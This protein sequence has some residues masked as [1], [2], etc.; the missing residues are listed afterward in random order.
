V[1]VL[2]VDK[3][4]ERAWSSSIRITIVRFFKAKQRQQQQQQQQLILLI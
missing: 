3:G 4:V 1:L 2:E